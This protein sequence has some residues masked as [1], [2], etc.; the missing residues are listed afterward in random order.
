MK[1]LLYAYTHTYYKGQ[2]LPLLVILSG[3][4]TLGHYFPLT[5]T[6]PLSRRQRQYF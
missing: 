3:S 2:M 5:R 4:W 1:I 6:P